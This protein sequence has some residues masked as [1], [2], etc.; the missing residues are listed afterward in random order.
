MWRHRHP[1]ARADSRKEVRNEASLRLKAGWRLLSHGLL[2]PIIAPFALPRHKGCCTFPATG[3]AIGNSP[4]RISVF[5]LHG[6]IEREPCDLGK[7]STRSAIRQ[8]LKGGPLLLLGGGLLV[9]HRRDSTH[10]D[11]SCQWSPRASALAPQNLRR[12]YSSN[13]GPEWSSKAPT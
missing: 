10:C 3:R 9:G 12:K 1:R 8:I 2:S 7:P 4:T 5:D 11:R 13:R 6:L